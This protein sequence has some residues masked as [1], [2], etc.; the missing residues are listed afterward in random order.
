[1]YRL[2]DLFSGIGGFSLGLERSGGFKTVA[3]CEIDPYCR[4]VLHKHWPDVFIHDDIRTLTKETL[5]RGYAENALLNQLCKE[6]GGNSASVGNAITS[7]RKRGATRTSRASMS[8]LPS[9][10]EALSIITAGSV[11]VAESEN[12]LSWRLITN[13][14]TETKSAPRTRDLCGSLLSSEDTLATIKFFATTATWQNPSMVPAHIKSLLGV[15]N[16][17]R[18]AADGIGVDAICGGFPCQD[19]SSA[20]AKAGIRGERSGLWFEYARLIGELRP[21]YVIVEN[22]GALLARGLDAVLGELASLGYDAEWHCIPA[23]AVGAPHQRDRLWLV[24]YADHKS[25]ST[26]AVNDE[27]RRMPRLVANSDHEGTG[28]R[29]QLKDGR[30]S[31]RDVAHAIGARQSGQGKPIF[32]SHTAASLQGKATDAFN[33]RVGD[34]WATEPDV[35]RVAHGVPNRMDRLR[36][37]GNSVVPAIPELIG[38]AIIAAERE[39]AP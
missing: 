4:R 7:I 15:N 21:R 16:Y 29:K 31:A 6:T 34:F 5:C 13:L 32:A 26:S 3:F 1:M 33:G 12:T 37:L 28:R 30:E 36:A 20:G 8:E 23:S 39:V 14:I 9:V 17:D 10:E 11:P 18:L 24:G 19:I 2:L 22:V 27:A 38:R 25:Q 35:G